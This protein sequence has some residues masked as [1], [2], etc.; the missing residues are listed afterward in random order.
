MVDIHCHILPAVD[1]GAK[2]IEESIT[3]ISTEVEGGTTCFVATP[4]VYT[5]QDIRNSTELAAHVAKLQ[6]AVQS[7][8]IQVQIVQ[9]A[10][11]FPSVAIGPAL[12]MDLPLTP[13]GHR[14]HMLIDLP[15]S[16]LPMNFGDILFDIQSRGITPIIAHPE[17]NGS[18]QSD[19][20]LLRSY[21]DKGMVCQVNAG[22]VRGK[23]GEKA[24]ECAKTILRRHW[25]HFLASD[26]HG[27]RP[28]PI[29]RTAVEELEAELDSAYL[30]ILTTTSGTCIAQGQPLPALPPAP[31]EPPKGFLSRLF[32]R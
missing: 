4:H 10:E 19:L 13:G 9:G 17:R 32:K 25:A 24:R 26:A 14:K 1:D 29:L 21:L 8:G 6:E 27:P 12:D 3:L 28:K 11:V 18:F 22:S 16:T 2:N 23:Y 7:A 31:P 30:E 20:G 5:D 15:M